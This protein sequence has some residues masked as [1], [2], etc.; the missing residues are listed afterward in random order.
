MYSV[1]QYPN[2]YNNN[3]NNTKYNFF[4]SRKTIRSVSNKSIDK[5]I[6]NRI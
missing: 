2:P 5:N 3:N 4:G 6:S 1:N